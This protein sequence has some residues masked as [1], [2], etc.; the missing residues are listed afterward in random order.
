MVLDH[1]EGYASRSA[2]M[3]SICQK[4]GCSRDSLRIWVQQEETD[5]DRQD[6]LASEERARIQELDRKVQELRQ[7]NT[8]L[9]KAS[10]YFA[11][12]EFDR[13]LKR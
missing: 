13:P 8:I 1:E 11:Q 4:V 7:A 2:A 6:G 12:A 9:E 5:I 10:V 3:L